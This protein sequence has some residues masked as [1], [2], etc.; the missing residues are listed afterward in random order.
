[1]EKDAYNGL[2]PVDKLADLEE[3]LKETKGHRHSSLNK[4]VPTT[5]TENGDIDPSQSA[6]ERRRQ[7]R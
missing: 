5:T 6:D 4:N 1:M 7:Q 3:G 2:I